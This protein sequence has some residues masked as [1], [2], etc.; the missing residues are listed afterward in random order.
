[1]HGI[2]RVI[3]KTCPQLMENVGNLIEIAEV[4]CL[5]F[6]DTV[7]ERQSL[8]LFLLDL[9]T[10]LQKGVLIAGLEK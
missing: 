9:V 4:T 8:D 10:S 7:V 2:V 5:L 1:M 3:M 6:T